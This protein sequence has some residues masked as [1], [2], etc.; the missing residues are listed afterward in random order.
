[1]L[2]K[3]EG[4]VLCLLHAEEFRNVE[5]PEGP[6]IVNNNNENKLKK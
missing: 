3:K 6:H 5:P 1:M 2:E 4:A